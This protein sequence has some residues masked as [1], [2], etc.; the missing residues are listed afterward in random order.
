MKL[1]YSKFREI[2]VLPLKNEGLKSTLESVFSNKDTLTTTEFVKAIVNSKVDVAII[3]IL[4]GKKVKEIDAVEGG[5]VL[6]NFFIYLKNNKEKF[7]SLVGLFGFGA[8]VKKTTTVGK[9]LR[10]PV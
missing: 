4:S 5:E 1:T 8:G 2:M 3:E 6:S 10:K 7:M 9:D